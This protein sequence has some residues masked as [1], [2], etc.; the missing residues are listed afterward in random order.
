MDVE[1]DII[2][3]MLAAIGSASITSTVGRHP[4]V[5]RSVPILARTNRSIQARGHWFNT[6]WCLPI[7]GS[8]IKEFILPDSAIKA[9][10]SDKSLPYVR[11][12]R[13]LYDPRKHTFQIDATTI[14]M[15][16]VILLGYEDL[17][18]A[19][20]DLIRA[21]AIWE[22]VQNSDMD[23]I[24]LQ[25]RASAL[26]TAKQAFETERLSQADYSIRTNPNYARIMGGLTQQYSRNTPSNIGG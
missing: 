22:L 5:L 19:A 20:V 10:T 12:G 11:R 1:L 3:A 23:S 4:G 14:N 21:T 25:S 16:V 8:D 2:N 13:Q 18:E 17:P 9:D 7:Q 26:A 24:S 6:D 15:D